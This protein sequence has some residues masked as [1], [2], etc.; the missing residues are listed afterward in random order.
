MEPDLDDELDGWSVEH[1]NQN[2]RRTAEGVTELRGLGRAV[3]P[4]VVVSLGTNDAG[5]A[6]A[7][8]RAHVD[9]VVALAGPS[10]CVVWLTISLDDLD[11]LNGV[12][13]EAA[14]EHSNLELADWGAL[15]EEEPELL[16]F[17]G[18][19]GTPAGYERRAELVA[20]I[21]RRCLPPTAA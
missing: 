9:E 18:V 21:A 5:M 2:G 7:E 4:V 10:R 12:L 20:G 11:E 13:R 19:H 17:D 3:E 15:V 14:R 16:A 6:P 8:F 1:H